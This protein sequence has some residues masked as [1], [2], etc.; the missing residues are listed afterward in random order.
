MFKLFSNIEIDGLIKISDFTLSNQIFITPWS[1]VHFMSGY[2]MLLLGFNYFWGFLIHSVY[3]YL[4]LTNQSIK[5][6]W[7]QFYKGFRTDSVFNSIGDT[8]FF[9]LGMYVAK[10]YNNNLLL[11]MVF[12]TG[13]LFFTPQ[14]QLSLAKSRYKYIKQLYPK[15]TSDNSNLDLKMLWIWILTCIIVFIKL[16]FKL[17]CKNLFT[18]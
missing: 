1:S 8:V 9:L 14:Y 15:I 6:N 11:F 12:L 7:K 16:N 13:I 4:N 17:L 18:Y 2:I 10:K 5:N 3:E